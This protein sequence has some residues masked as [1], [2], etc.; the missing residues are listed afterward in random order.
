MPTVKE[1]NIQLEN[2]PGALGKVCKALAGRNVNILAFQASTAERRSQVH[3]VVDNPGAAKIA[4]SAERLTYTESEIVEVALPN[5]PGELAR[6][7]SR[8]GHANIN[9][10]YAYGGSST[11]F[12]G[13]AEVGRAAKI[14][15]QAAAA[16]GT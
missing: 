3:L 12:F 8:L 4:L 2:Q 5:R 1:L 10:N 15:D 16:G 11:L 13:V 9:I 7:A 14:L 6:V